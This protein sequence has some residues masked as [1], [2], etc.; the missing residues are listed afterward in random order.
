[1]SVWTL[2]FGR[3]ID[4]GRTA[5]KYAQWKFR[6]E[7]TNWLNA[8]YLQRESNRN[9]VRATAQAPI[10]TSAVLVGLFLRGIRSGA[11]AGFL[12]G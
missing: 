10:G 6:Y 5:R 9:H 11:L 12:V 7:I 3:V 1:M 8:D 4:G 2:G